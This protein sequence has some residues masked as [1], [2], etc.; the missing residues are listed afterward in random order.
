VIRAAESL[1]SR[2]NP[3][4][5]ATRSW[6][7]GSYTF[8]VIIDN[9]MN[10]ELLFHAQ[11]LRGGG[12]LRR[13]AET[14]ARTTLAHHFRPDCSS[15]HVVDFD[16]ASGRV[17]RKQ[18][19]QGLADE[20]AW[21]RGQ[22]WGLYGF[23]VAYRETGEPE[24]L[25]QARRIAEFYVS[26]PAMPDD[27]VPF[28][29]FDAPTRTDVPKLRD[30]SAAAIAASAL[31]EL[32]GFVDA[33]LAE[34]YRSFAMETLRSLSLP[35]YRATLGDNGHFLLRNSVG[36]FPASD[37]LGVAINYADYYYLEALLRGTVAPESRA[38]EASPA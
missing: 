5:G 2:F 36:N 22:A 38:G 28:F 23:S 16:P 10:L 13:I 7:F 37:E 1:A 32:A 12:S 21:A 6:D 9:M 30:A 34:R 18:T 19:H 15:Y 17:L 14:H 35:P 27:F 31:L 4:V 3:S 25:D 24:F 29:D 8:P 33:A 20:S 11:K 26:H